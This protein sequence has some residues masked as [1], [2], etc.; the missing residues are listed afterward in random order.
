MRKVHLGLFAVLF[1]VL[2]ASPVFAEGQSAF[3]SSWGF[4]LEV[5]GEWF[6]FDPETNSAASGTFAGEPPQDEVGIWQVP[7]G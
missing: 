4:F 1:L 2:A 6:G 7:G 3:S 5:L